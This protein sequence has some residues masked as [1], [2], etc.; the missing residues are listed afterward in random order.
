MSAMVANRDEFFAELDTL[1]DQEIEERLPS[2]DPGKL[3]LVQQYIDRGSL[4]SSQKHAPNLSEQMPK[5]LE[6]D[7]TAKVA[8]VVALEEARKANT[9][10]TS[11]LIL[12]VGAMLGA[13]AAGAVAYVA[14][15]N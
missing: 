15:H 10:A 6:T 3:L 11:A 4:E 7:A 1:T 2:W 5:Q 14:L 9:I 13:I 12:S 8:A